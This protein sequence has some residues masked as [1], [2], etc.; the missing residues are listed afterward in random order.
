MIKNLI[1]FLALIV[2]LPNIGQAQWALTATGQSFSGTNMT[3]GYSVGELFT[4]SI[5]DPCITVHYLPGVIQSSTECPTSVNNVFDDHY[6]LKCY[7]NPTEDR[8][9]IET[10]FLD[11]RQYQIAN[12]LGQTTASGILEGTEIDLTTLA[13]GIYLIT[14][15][16]D[17]QTIY[18][19][20]KIIKQ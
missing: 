19:S 2:F 11:F 16:S 4:T 5:G 10:D 13:S 1:P 12:M 8:I 18:K 14:L 3:I 6:Y 17:D 15:I 9:L 20:F 7:P